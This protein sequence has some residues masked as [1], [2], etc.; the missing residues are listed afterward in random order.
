MFLDCNRL[1]HKGL[2]KIADSGV[3]EITKERLD[4]YLHGQQGK[5]DKNINISTT[6]NRHVTLNGVQLKN[7]G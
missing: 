4:K 1:D 7:D 2:L 6:M 3:S 5:I